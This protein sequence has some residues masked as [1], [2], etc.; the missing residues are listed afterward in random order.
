MSLLTRDWNIVLVH[1][2][3]KG[4]LCTDWL[5]K[6]GDAL[7]NEIR[8]YDICPLL[9][10]SICLPNA[11]GYLSLDHSSSFSFSHW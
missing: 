1:T 4:N 5:T 9:L 8:V 6:F 2:L 10:T 3:Q 7:D 11:M